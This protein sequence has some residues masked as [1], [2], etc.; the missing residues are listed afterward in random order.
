M[1]HLPHLPRSTCELPRSGRALRHLV[2]VLTLLLAAC[3]GGSSG[4]SPGGVLVASVTV[5]PTAPVLLVG[6][7][8][9]LTAVSRDANGNVLGGRAVAWSSNTPGVASVSTSGLVTG[10]AVGA[11]TITATVENITGSSAITTLNAPQISAV[12]PT[13]LVPGTL[14]T[15]TGT[16][17]DPVPAND[18]VTVQGVV[19]V[20]STVTATQISFFVP[21]VA[22]GTVG[23]RVRTRVGA[24]ALQNATLAGAIRTIALGQA[25][26]SPDAASTGCTEL[27][28]AATPARYLVAV[29]SNATNQNALTDFDIAGNG[30]GLVPD[31]RPSLVRALPEMAPRGEVIVDPN[32]AQ[33]RRAEA[34]HLAFLERERQWY[35]TARP[36]GITMQSRVAVAPRPAVALGDTRNFF[37]TF[38]GG[39]NDST[40][41][42]SAK[43]IYVG[44][45][46]IVWED[47]SNSLQSSVLPALLSNY[48]RLGAQFDAEQYR[49]D[50]L[51]FGDPLRRDA[52]TDN[53]G[54][55]QM[56][57]T[58]RLNA[59][60]AAAYVTACDQ[61]ARAPSF[62]G[63]NF[64][65]VFYG[66]VPSVATPSVS[67][68]NAVDGWFA[69]MGRTVV[70]EVKHIVSTAARVANN[71]PAFEESWLE[72]GTARMA[73]EM[74]VR[75]KIHNAA[76]K[77]NTGFGTAA[78]NGLFCD[79]TLAD[80]TCL[81]NDA[82]HRP[83]WGLRRQFD[84]LL[85]KLQQPWNWSLFGDGTAQSG[86]V[87]YQTTW[88]LV[89][90][91]IDRYAATEE[92]FLNALTGANITGTSNLAARAG[93]PFET[94]LGGWGL[95]L[96]ADDYPGLAG[97]SADI[98]YQTWNL[99][100]IYA[101]LNAQP[102]WA[103][104]FPTAFPVVP[105]A[106]TWG[107][108]SQ[109]VIGVRGGAHMLF[110]LSGTPGANQLIGIAGTGG[111]SGAPG[112]L[113][114]AITRIQ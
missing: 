76:W 23:V 28:L 99:R 35:A 25:Y 47:A 33:V 45:K 12:N 67:N 10:L 98:Q 40:Q 7:T 38:S 107:A 94:L 4:T 22:S 2:S 70:H 42:V 60:G 58:Q 64:G 19:A 21:C 87:Y 63:S 56:V 46:A 84:E 51:Y 96:Y 13:T 97:A 31:T 110:E 75:T 59:T 15:L 34:A 53:D 29:F 95:A 39:C 103:A 86:S 3:G 71:A 65:E 102:A 106:L 108:F 92:G 48:T 14:A 17:F 111:G 104:R 50:S 89:R 109:R 6:A 20:I 8:Q 105:T 69:F 73:E 62:S 9:Q 79:F 5:S 72:E 44:S 61:F 49:S 77:G 41:V 26:I 91:T 66:F 27:A 18:T 100:N 24:S 32:A 57:F 78:S 85:P 101:G 114:I 80:A 88:S 82:T 90:Y 36:R 112:T 55:V 11:S 43:A 81:A 37:F 74:W 30:V 113:R 52:V 93:V 54:H 1:P 68:I 16:S 83:T